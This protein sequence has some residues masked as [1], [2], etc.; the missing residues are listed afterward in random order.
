MIFIEQ[1][2]PK[3]IKRPKP[4]FADIDA[5]DIILNLFID[6]LP[7]TAEEPLNTDGKVR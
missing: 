6:P 2:H 5:G 7:C 4:H 1:E 3:T